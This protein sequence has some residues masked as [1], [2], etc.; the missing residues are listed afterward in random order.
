MVK[1]LIVEDS[2]F[3]RKA[4]INLLKK[5]N[6][7]NVIEASDGYEGVKKY[8]EERPDLLLLDLRLP[9]MMS[10]FDVFREI[11][12]MNPFIKCIIIS[13]IRKEGTIKEALEL[14]VKDY[15]TK[16]VTE[17]KLVPIVKKV[18]GE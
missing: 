3:E 8:K 11:K 18:V 5:G 2:L 12:K 14:G 16:P 13:I 6:Y 7:T 9:G 1:I 10:G 15:I 4:I 17:E